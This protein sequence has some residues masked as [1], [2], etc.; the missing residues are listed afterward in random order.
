LAVERWILLRRFA[1]KVLRP[2][3]SAILG[4]ELVAARSID[5]MFSNIFPAL[6]RQDR[7]AARFAV[8]APNA[9]IADHPTTIIGAAD[10]AA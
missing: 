6:R 4:G 8:V 5:A 1:V 2:E 7:E 3:L 9:N 10:H